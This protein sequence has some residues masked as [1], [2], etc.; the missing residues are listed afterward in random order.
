MYVGPGATAR[1]RE[2]RR[3]IVQAGLLAATGK[4]T[5]EGKTRPTLGD[6]LGRST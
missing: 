1:P 4:A 2:T 6:G 5:T 3:S